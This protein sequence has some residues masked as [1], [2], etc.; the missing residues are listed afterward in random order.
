MIILHITIKKNILK[1]IS[2]TGIGVTRVVDPDKDWPDPDPNLEKIPNPVP[3]QLLRKV[4]KYMT[5]IHSI[6]LLDG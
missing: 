5:N 6:V 1:N 3:I 4:Q 2:R